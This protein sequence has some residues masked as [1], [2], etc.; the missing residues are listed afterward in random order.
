MIDWLFVDG[1]IEKTVL[2]SDKEGL[3]SKWIPD[4]FGIVWVYT[5]F[6]YIYKSNIYRIAVVDSSSL[7]PS[8]IENL[9]DET[10]I[11]PFC[12]L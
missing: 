12:S 2:L 1:P 6:N 4:S 5:P 10:D 11:R 9:I 3:D 8:L 7:L